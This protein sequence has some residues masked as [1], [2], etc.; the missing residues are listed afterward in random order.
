MKELEIVTKVDFDK[1]D[2]VTVAMAKIERLIRKNVRESKKRR[3][4]LAG[5]INKAEKQIE[6]FG[7][8]NP[9]KNMV[10]KMS[11]IYK[12][13]KFAGILKTIGVEIE[14]NLSGP[15]RND[16]TLQIAKKDDTGKLTSQSVVIVHKSIVYTKSQTSLV[17][18][19]KKMQE[20]QTNITRA[21]VNW[22]AKLS[23]MSAVE[24]QMR[25]KVVESQLNK[26]PEGKALIN[27]LTK[28]YEQTVKA[29][30]M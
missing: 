14:F 27:V 15:E 22:K 3:D 7:K 26:T 8:N 23:D 6:L 30:E 11:K 13:F 16:Y 2:I 20:E 12:A 29:L 24:R 1:Q 10:Q 25:A 17:A 28:D 9:P 5:L 21:G 19:I 18:K 4:E